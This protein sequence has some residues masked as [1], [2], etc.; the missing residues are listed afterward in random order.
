[1]SDDDLFSYAEKIAVRARS[2]DPSTSKQAA[3]ILE[4]NQ[5][6]VS[7]SVEIVIQILRRYGPVLSDFDIRNHWGEFMLAKWSEGLPRMARL[8][9]QRKNLVEQCGEGV[10]NGRKCRLWKEKA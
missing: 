3:A 1:M 5:G 6:R 4:S 9:A 7:F 2:S 10:H 8:W